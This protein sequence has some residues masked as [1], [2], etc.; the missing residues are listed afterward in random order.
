MIRTILEVVAMM[1]RR[2]ASRAGTRTSAID[3]K[4][5]ATGKDRLR[6]IG[7]TRFRPSRAGD[8]LRIL[9]AKM[10]VTGHAFATISAALKR[11]MSLRQ[12][13][14]LTGLR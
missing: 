3:P 1:A 5:V 9:R 12:I 6:M 4:T 2:T 13:A 11:Q 10:S 7:M 14:A 8:Q